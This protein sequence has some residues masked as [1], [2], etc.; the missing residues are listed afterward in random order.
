MITQNKK[1]AHLARTEAAHLSLANSA[2]A[3][4]KNFL[5]SI[6]PEYASKIVDGIK[7][8]ELRKKF[9]TEGVVGGIVIVYSSSPVKH[10]VGYGYIREVRK[11]SVSALWR[12]YGKLSCVTKSFFE[13]YFSGLN[14]GVAI[15]LS[16]V[17]KLKKPIPLDKLQRIP[18]IT[19]P[20]SYRYAT[21]TMIKTVTR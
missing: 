14:E 6:K 20:Q 16:E 1:K 5:I 19:A 11:A 4:P 17:V 3:K 18:R 15:I 13:S 12:R 2:S 9:P 7:T 21:D 8:V 10:I